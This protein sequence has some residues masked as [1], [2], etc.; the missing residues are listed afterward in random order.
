VRSRDHLLEVYNPML[1]M[2]EG[3]FY[4]TG[5]NRFWK[6]YERVDNNP[7]HAA[8][9]KKFLAF[10]DQYPAVLESDPFW[11]TRSGTKFHKAYT[12]PRSVEKHLYN[13]KE[14]KFYNED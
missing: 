4:H 10:L 12:D 7:E 1:G 14:Y 5:G 3:R 9:K 2:P 8:V 13:H 6:G 11:E